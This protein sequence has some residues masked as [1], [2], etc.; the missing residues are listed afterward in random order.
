MVRPHPGMAQGVRSLTAAISHL[1]RSPAITPKRAA[2][3]ERADIGHHIAAHLL[4]L[5]KERARDLRDLPP[6]ESADCRLARAGLGVAR[7]VVRLDQRS[8]RE[9][10]G[11]VSVV[12]TATAWIGAKALAHPTATGRE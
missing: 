6:G 11:G 4:I 3:H 9:A 5:I 10:F 8:E 1:T 7:G 2:I 12:E